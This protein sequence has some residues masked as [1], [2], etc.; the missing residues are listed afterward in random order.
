MGSELVS[1]FGT[2]VE[3]GLREDAGA[4]GGLRGVGEAGAMVS[5]SNPPPW[6]ISVA[7]VSESIAWPQDEQNLAFAEDFAPHVG[8]NMRGGNLT[9]GSQHAAR[10][11]LRS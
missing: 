2:G 1:G 9:T 11:T 3:R 6:S 5:P 8:Q 10:V 4:E 7:P